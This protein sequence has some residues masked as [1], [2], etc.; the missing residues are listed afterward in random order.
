MYSKICINT[1]GIISIMNINVRKLYNINI[2]IITSIN[3][4]NNSANTIINIHV[5]TKTNINI[6]I[7]LMRLLKTT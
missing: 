4:D 5:V 7:T 3:N 1:N 2:N 6:G